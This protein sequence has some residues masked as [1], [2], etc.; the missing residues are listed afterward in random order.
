MP[1]HTI[2]SPSPWGTLFTTL[3]S[4]NRSPTQ[5]HLPGTVEQG[6]I[7]EEH[8][9]PARPVAVEGE[10]LPTEVGYDTELQSSQD[11]GEDKR[12]SLR[13][14]LTVCAEILRLCKTHSLI[15]CPADDP[16]DEEAGCRGPGLALLHVVCSCEASWMY[17]QILDNNVEDGL[18]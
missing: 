13:R 17:C 10:R 14:F 2:T 3:T 12:A 1:A 15:S 16:A 7:C 11:P 18:W 9:S 6:V 4:A 5:C 8:T